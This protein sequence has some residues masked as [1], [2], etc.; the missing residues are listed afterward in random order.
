M[1]VSLWSF[2]AVS[3]QW[4]LTRDTSPLAVAICEIRPQ[5][6][7]ISD[8]RFTH[9]RAKSRKLEDLLGECSLHCKSWESDYF[10]Y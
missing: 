2:R 9:S 3:F 8:M 1:D 10:R 6:A 5:F 7:I 4:A